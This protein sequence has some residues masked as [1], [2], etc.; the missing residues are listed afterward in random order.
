[1]LVCSR[2]TFK[3]EAAAGLDSSRIMMYVTFVLVL[4]F[5]EVKALVFKSK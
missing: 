4:S 2:S 5:P 3:S 1:M